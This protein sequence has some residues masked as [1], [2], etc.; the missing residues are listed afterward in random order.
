MR[1]EKV[2]GVGLVN[3]LTKEYGDGQERKKDAKQVDEQAARWEA[4][5]AKAALDGLGQRRGLRGCK[6]SRDEP[7]KEYGA[8][9]CGVEHPRRVA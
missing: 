9:R 8:A 3:V 6:A 2:E 4:K 1:Q 7:S 5:A